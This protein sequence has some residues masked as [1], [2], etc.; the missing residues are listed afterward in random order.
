MV[1]TPWNRQIQSP[2]PVPL[3][4]VLALRLSEQRWVQVQKDHKELLAL[5]RNPIPGLMMPWRGPIFEVEI[6]RIFAYSFSMEFTSCQAKMLL[7]LAGQWFCFSITSRSP[8]HPPQTFCLRSNCI[9]HNLLVFKHFK[10]WIRSCPG[11]S[12][13]VTS[14]FN[15]GQLGWPLQEGVKL[16]KL[17]QQL[18]YTVRDPH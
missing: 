11:P 3:D 10:G 1:W 15:L 16:I 12:D 2:A 9:H 7:Q 5:G 8:G 17:L 18:K 14:L 4:F 6:F 13:Y